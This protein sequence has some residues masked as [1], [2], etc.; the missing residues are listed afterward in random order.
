MKNILL[1]IIVSMIVLSCS[2]NSTDDKKQAADKRIA[3]RFD[4][5]NTVRLSDTLVI[6]E[7]TCRGCAYEGSTSFG[8]VDSMEIIKL[9]DVITIDNNSPEM[10]GGNVSK[11]VILVP[12]KTGVTNFRF[13]KFWDRPETAAD[14]GMFRYYKI[15]VKQ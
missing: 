4:T 8:I 6:F 13:Y 14:S 11:Q 1:I 2:N 9:A 10:A 3:L 5:V 12:L 15:E 7:S